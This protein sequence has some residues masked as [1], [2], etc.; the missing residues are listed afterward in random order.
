[1]TR[2]SGPAITL[3]AAA[4]EEPTEDEE[5]NEKEELKV[6]NREDLLLKVGVCNVQRKH[7]QREN[8]KLRQWTQSSQLDQAPELLFEV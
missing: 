4:T 3:R 7:A 2:T 6:G 8:S 5:G 1:M